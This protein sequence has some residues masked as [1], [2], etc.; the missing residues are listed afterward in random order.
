MLT[1]EEVIQQMAAEGL[2]RLPDGHPVLNGKAQRFGPKKK[3]WYVLREIELKSGRKI[4]TGAF[5]VWQGQNPNSIPITMDWAGLSP[6]E[7]AE[8]E[9]KQAAHE[10]AEAERKQRKA[11]LAAGRAR[12]AWAAAAD[13]DQ[14]SAY[15]ARKRVQS[16][17]TRVDQDGVLLVPVMKYSES[18]ATLAG[19][20]RIQP[21]GE[22]RF[23]SGID[24]V[25]GACLLGRLSPE[26]R[27][28]EIGEGYAT[29][30][31]VRMATDFDTPVM[32]AFNAGNLLPV[33]RL[34]RELFPDAHLLFHADDDMRLIARL[35]EFLLKEYDTVWEPV[36]DGKDHELSNAG[37]DAVCVRATW[38]EDMTKTPYIEADIRSG[39]RVQVT[40]FENAGVSRS[41]AA[42]RAVGNASVS[43]PVF[44]DRP[45]DSKASDYNDLY[46]AESLDVVRD[47]VLVARSRALTMSEESQPVASEEDLPAYLDA[48]PLPDV[49][50][51][52]EPQ[53][54][55]SDMR[56][57]TLD[58][59]LEHFQLI[60]PTTD[61]WDSRRKQRLK[62]SAFTAWVGKEL[63]A[64]WEKA[65]N[66]RT[67][68]RDSLPTLVGGKAVEGNGSG[69]KLGEMLDNL[70]LLR[71]TETVWDG[72]G[73]QVMSLG[74]VRADYTAEL[75]GKWQEHAQRKTIEARNLVFD[76]TQLADP[77]SHV[78]I[79]LGWPL[80]PKH[81]PD[82]IKPI[83]A[84]LA[85]LCDAE[86]RADEYMEWILRWLAYPLQ[87][88]GAKMQTALLMF[89]E[90][91]GTGKS[92]FFEGVML[93]IF[94][95]YGTVASQH[96]LDSTFTSWR[97]KKLFVLFEEVLSRDDKYS[98]NGTLKYMITG[99]TM[100]I[101]EKNLPARDE[102]NH[103]NSVFLSNEPQPIPIELEDRR[104]MVI[105]ARRKQDPAFYN[106]VKDAIANGA[107]EAFY[108][109]LLTLPLDDF[110]EHTKPPMTLAKERV[111][112][113][114]LA[115]WMSFHRAWKDGYLDAP[116]C[117]CL[118]EDL[119]IIYKRWCDKSG[120]KPLTLCKFAGL[121]GGREHKA[122]KS[123]AVDSKHKKTRMVFVVENADFPH[124]LDE[125]IAKFRE[126]GKVRADRAL[127]GYAE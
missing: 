6:E 81:D 37:G 107:I 57:P 12:Q 66:R 121:I 73:Q 7:R 33:A 92:L 95:D 114:G 77:V 89:G 26:T 13:S 68:M 105:E 48:A 2:P 55:Q 75:T 102:R 100:N 101:N 62:K 104:F 67:I 97:S 119:Y 34:L 86:D 28:I 32:V 108:H 118:S 27:L 56:A 18:G 36:I 94:G 44:A 38:R 8:A 106:Q 76:P 29:C 116:Y 112:E 49:L 9:R 50:P 63:A 15:L 45:A 17:K 23:S 22:K 124:P 1:R 65:P 88:P 54:I 21:D 98:H 82:L 111:I 31:T 126:L 25:A 80:K 5:G 10:R 14:P 103:M 3:A 16:E 123:V 20:Q 115:G 11:E 96:Q 24:M 122:K 42:A 60:Y 87:H 53:D 39:R 79:F 46:L 59:L 71:G 99:K 40:K 43:I 127:Q 51:A 41:R 19:L 113:F 78:N 84:L 85:S 70:T 91:Q 61:V 109:F 125:Q 74:A 30:E 72:I 117:S 58:V 120:E 64:G 93:P 110:N 4:V 47:Q 52:A 69:G 83:L 35:G 90:K